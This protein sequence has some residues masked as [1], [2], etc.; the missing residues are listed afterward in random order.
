LQ[1]IEDERKVSSFLFK[2]LQS[3]RNNEDILLE[4]VS[5]LQEQLKTYD[6]FSNKYSI[7]VID[8]LPEHIISSKV[9]RG[10]S[11]NE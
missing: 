8:T 6:N 5:Q 10:V 3:E 7:T 4:T 9:D 11:I 1:K 2:E